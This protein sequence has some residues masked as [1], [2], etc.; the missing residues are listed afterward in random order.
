MGRTCAVLLVLAATLL[1]AKATSETCS[2]S[3]K[4]QSALLDAIDG[5]LSTRLSFSLLMQMQS[6]RSTPKPLFRS[7][8]KAVEGEHRA[9]ELKLP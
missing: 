7:I 3:G 4:A 1:T 8:P 6:W 2:S 9:V 5:P